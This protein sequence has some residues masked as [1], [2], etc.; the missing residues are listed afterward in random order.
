[1]NSNVWRPILVALTLLW[2]VSFVPFVGASEEPNPDQTGYRWIDNKDPAPKQAYNWI[3]ISD[4]GTDLLAG[5]KIDLNDGSVG[6]TTPFLPTLYGRLFGMSGAPLYVSV[7]GLVCFGTPLAGVTSAYNT[8]LPTQAAPNNIIAVFWDD[9]DASN[10]GHIYY[11]IRGEAPNRVMVIQWSNLSFNGQT[12]NLNFQLQIFETETAT[13]YVF[14]YGNMTSPDAGRATG[15][16]ATIGI[17]NGDGTRAT[18]YSYNVPNVIISN[19][20]AIGFYPPEELLGSPRFVKGAGFAD[21]MRILWGQAHTP[22]IVALHFFVYAPVE[23]D[24][25]I[26]GIEIKADLPDNPAAHDLDESKYI[27]GVNVY[28]DVDRNASISSSE[29]NN[30]QV[31][32]WA[33]SAQ[34]P[35]ANNGVLTLTFTGQTIIATA[36]RVYIVE[37]VFD[38]TATPL[39]AENE[40]FKLLLHRV[41]YRGILSNAS[42]IRTLDYAT[43]SIYVDDGVNPYGSLSVMTYNY[44][45]PTIVTT[46]GSSVVGMAFKVTIGTVEDIRWQTLTVRGL[47]TGNIQNDITSV[48]FYRDQNV[49]GRL[50]PGEPTAG[51]SFAF[52][53]GDMVV[54]NNPFGQ[55]FVRGTIGY[56][57]AV[58]TFRASTDL[59][60]I[61]TTNQI[62]FQFDLTYMNMSYY[63]SP[64][65]LGGTIVGA[66]QPRVQEFPK[67][68]ILCNDA[69][70]RVIRIG[71]QEAVNEDPTGASLEGGGC[72]VAT[73]A[74]GSY[75]SNTVLRLCEVRDTV[76]GG[77]A[78]GTALTD[79]YY[80]VSP[81]VAAALRE[82]ASLRKLVGSMV[83]GVVK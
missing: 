48:A 55:D 9:L 58:I 82:S 49:N 83:E 4:T 51:T 64:S 24:I 46:P 43:G 66:F 5:T 74:F 29:R 15:S 60:M 20:T 69:V 3:E 81:R 76:L 1:M 31:V 28:E 45:S 2:C 68:A 38:T 23:E 72:F 36:S 77:T 26:T 30:N 7:N 11:D 42:R 22:S 19:E 67:P 33:P 52:A 32:A 73:A 13:P 47:S 56:Y 65:L 27:A 6:I 18:L 8:T 34:Q 78:S 79:L 17:E 53:T 70:G 63:T 12:A 50:D 54:V 71:T 59:S 40:G 61:N 10:G 16:G 57:L 14:V 39:P 41:S 37:V 21:S 75:S 35:F 25:E 44:D 62:V 80:G